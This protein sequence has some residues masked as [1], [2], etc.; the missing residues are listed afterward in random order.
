MRTVTVTGQ[1]EA[2]VLPDSA[3]VSVSAVHR[4]PGVAEALAGADSAAVAIAATARDFTTPE[5]VR[6]TSFQIWR[7]HDLGR[8]SDFRARHSLVIGCPDIAA[9]GGLVTALAEAV[10]ERLEIEGVSLEV[11]DQSAASAAAREAAYADAVDRATQLASLTSAQLGEPQQVT[12]GGGYGGGPVR[13]AA[14]T[15]KRD[16]SFQPGETTVSATVTVTFQLR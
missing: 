14:M 4:A 16:A 7:D 13:M 11:A 5:R 3:V 8:P 15:L 10:G 9:A 12:E 6:S 1:G 2:R